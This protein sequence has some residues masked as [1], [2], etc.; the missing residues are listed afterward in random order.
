MTYHVLL[1]QP[2]GMWR[3]NHFLMCRV[4]G[5]TQI[6]LWREMKTWCLYQGGGRWWIMAGGGG[7]GNLRKSVSAALV[8]WKGERHLIRKMA[9]HVFFSCCS[10]LC[11]FCRAS[12][13]LSL[14]SHWSS[15]GVE[16]G[17]FLEHLCRFPHPEKQL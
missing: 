16:V 3:L 12:P 11:P 10:H 17:E 7:K 6:T 13:Q 1:R 8:R 5:P 4:H 9:L 2:S 15:K 14:L